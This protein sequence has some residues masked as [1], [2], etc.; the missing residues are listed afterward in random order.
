[1]VALAK[2]RRC[3]IMNTQTLHTELRFRTSRSS[4]SGGQHVNKVNTQVELLFD[5]D[6]STQLTSAQK[7]LIHQY[8]SNR[9]DQSGILHIT[10]S[11]TRSQLRNKKRA[12]AKFDQLI[13]EALR[14]RPKRKKVKPLRVETEKRLR[15]KRL[16]SEKKALRKKV[17]VYH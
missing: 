1:M 17:D 11:G 2:S 12:I 16:H 13:E 10:S 9:I 4:G 7:Q 3:T 6:H 5:V 15:K 8:L 14:P